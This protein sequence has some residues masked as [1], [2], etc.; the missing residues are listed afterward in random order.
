MAST[1]SVRERP[2]GPNLLVR[3]WAPAGDPWAAILIV[4]G[5]AEHSGRYEAVGDAL[6]AAG[7]DVHALD[8]RGFGRSGGRRAYAARF[9]DF[10]ADVADRM[11][12]IRVSAGRLPVVLFGHSLGGLVVLGY[13]LGDGPKPDLAV[14]SAPALEDN[15]PAWKRSMAGVLVRVVPTL[16]FSNGLRG[17]MLASDPEVGRRYLADT[18]AYHRS[19][20]RLA[21]EMFTEQARVRAAIEEAELGRLSIPMLVYHGDADPIVPVRASERLAAVRRRHAGSTRAGDTRRTTNRE[22]RSS[23]TL[24][25]GSG[26]TCRT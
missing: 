17:E 4:H 23:P 16:E 11:A 20:V 9:A 6:G 15:V 21:V 8:L 22:R 26:N 1:T 18:D 24:S 2:D 3:H 19:T 13:L 10:H 14:V 5:L 12:A 25:P 7:L